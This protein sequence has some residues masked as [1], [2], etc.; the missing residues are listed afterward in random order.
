MIADMS[1]AR[2]LR[3]TAGV[4]V[5]LAGLSGPV[6]TR[7]ADAQAAG[8]PPQSAAPAPDR[9]V[10]VPAPATPASV[11]VQGPDG[12]VTVTATRLREA[13]VVDGRLHDA[14]YGEIEAVAGFIQQEP[15]EGEPATERTD[16]WIL[17]DDDALYIS[18]RCWDSQPAR[19]VA[20]EMRRD[21]RN[22]AQNES[23][24]VIL[25]TFHDRRNGFFFQTNPLGA[26]RDGLITDE[27]TANFDWNTVWDVQT[28]TTPDGWT[29][30]MV[31]PFKS[32]RYG[33]DAD[34][35]WGINVHRFVRWK[36][37]HSYLIPIPASYAAEGL[38]R[39]SQAA[40]LTGLHLQSGMRHLEIKPYAISGVTTNRAVTPSISNDLDGDIGVDAKYNLTE[41]L[42]ADFTYNTD[43][44]Q[45][46][47]DETQVNLTRFNLFFPEK[48]EFFL[49]GQGLF[50]FGGPERVVWNRPSN[51]PVVFFSRRI[52][53]S[54]GGVVPIRA[55]GRV[56][57]RVGKYSVGVLGI[58]TGPS[59]MS[60]EPATNFSVVRVRLDIL[61]RSS[62]GFIGT[63]RSVGSDGRGG[64]QVWGT[65]ASLA[66]RENLSI[67]GYYAKSQTPGRTGRDYSY[68]G[69]L[70]NFGDR[71]GIEFEHL[72]VGENFN[73]EIG[74]LR[75]S[76][77]RRN[78]LQLQFSPRPT[79]I[80][81]VRKFRNEFS[82]DYTTNL[83]GRLESRE[84]RYML[85]TEFQRGDQW[86]LGYERSFEFLP[87]PFEIS[88]GI[89][90]PVGGYSFRTFRSNYQL[91]PQR[92]LSGWLGIIRGT[93][94]DGDLTEARFRGRLEVTPQLS[95]EPNVKI[96]WVDLP[97]GTFTSQLVSGRVNYTISPRSFL[98]A[99]IQYNTSTESL[100]TN[101]RFR[102]EYE[103]G[104][105]LFVVYTEGRDTERVGFPMLENRGFVIKY[106]KLFRF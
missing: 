59:D 35:V 103:P 106:T 32:L 73:P 88:K 97:Q 1:I 90:L 69:R 55:G 26:L 13:V 101:L 10:V 30:E 29:L 36:N 82:F 41:G 83:D 19:M 46:E 89:V 76:N 53:L 4:G 33:G 15:S 49:E 60:A 102:W 54:D 56:T 45:V 2:Q 100:S 25:D 77:F 17:F 52:G 85:F 9:G 48:R 51:A 84:L 23:F 58:G 63:H 24:A 99:L 104:S 20:N 66:F 43:F 92:R 16:V 70:E 67:T 65:D 12:R 38:Y 5:L 86:E 21:H 64:N 105:D 27:R 95:I 7:A 75:R 34:Q 72:V 14:V 62:I 11:V 93:F 28:Q 44:S 6:P 3:L 42:T 8:V 80:P 50:E 87:A 94:F 22:V 68:R 91:G 39:V 74:F 81:S 37:E 78:Y 98:A 71:Y 79:S 40:T 31:I 96:S 47:A 61:R 18:A 57:G